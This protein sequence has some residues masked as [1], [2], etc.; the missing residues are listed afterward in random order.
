MSGSQLSRRSI[1]AAG[2]SLSLAGLP[3][4]SMA[5]KPEVPKGKKPK[6][7]IFMVADG[8]S[9]GAPTMLDHYL[10]LTANRSSFWSGLMGEPYVVNGLQDTRSLN[11]LVTDS[12]AAASAWGS[13]SYI[14]NGQVNAFPDKTKL[15]PLLHV[16]KEDAKMRTGLATTTRI[17]HATPSGFAIS[18]FSRDDEDG[19]AEEYTAG[20][21]DVMMGGGAR[22]FDPAKRKKKDDLFAKFSA[23]GYEVVLDKAGLKSA[24]GSRVLGLFAP[25]HLPYTIDHVNSPE[26]LATVPTLREMSTAA[27]A[28]LDGSSHGFILQIEAARVDHAAHGNDLAGLIFDQRAFDEAVQAVVE[29]ALKDGETLVVITTDHGNSNPGLVG[30]GE[31][32]I[33]STA[34]LLTLRHVSGSYDAMATKFGKAPDSSTIQDVVQ[35]VMRIKMAKKHA[36]FV[37]SF[38]TKTSPLQDHPQYGGFSGHLAIA[39]GPYTHVGWT[40]HDHTSDFGLVTALGPS[41]EFF[42]GVTRNVSY[43]GHMLAQKDVKF[44]NPTMTFE[45]AQEFYEKAKSGEDSF[46]CQ[47]DHWA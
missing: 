43:F 37:A 36:D 40:G 4:F 38:V 17:T 35:Q 5:E 30:A 23:M 22:H 39:L 27:I 19:I 20:H 29:W 12:A 1:L 10:Q 3:N 42:R 7:I 21:V 47:V 44:K 32:Y 41:A 6:N 34:G 45:V 33:D 14:W 18:R 28:L 8:M 24:K 46:A 11:S 16:L 25:D 2:A 9:T 13:G 15:R 26:L 31:E